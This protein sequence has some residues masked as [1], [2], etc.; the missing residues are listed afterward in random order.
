MAFFI[1]VLALTVC[2]GCS[3]LRSENELRR[4]L[5]SVEITL[6]TFHERCEEGDILAY[7][8]DVL[9]AEKIHGN[10]IIIYVPVGLVGAEKLKARSCDSI[11]ESDSRSNCSGCAMVPRIPVIG[12]NP[13]MSCE[14]A[15]DM[16][17][18]LT[19]TKW[20]ITDFGILI[21]IRTSN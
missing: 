15:L 9:V 6:D 19:L 5:Q 13:T 8:Q 3:T 16:F 12:L 21:Q 14:K 2:S 7:L 1:I 20:Q 11:H 4:K 10:A 18:D 17:C